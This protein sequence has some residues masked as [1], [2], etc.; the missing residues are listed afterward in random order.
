MNRY[1]KL[2]AEYDEELDIEEHK[3]RCDGLY[4]DNVIW[5]KA[6]L[7]SAEKLSIVAEELGHYK[8]TSGDILDQTITSNIKQELSARKWAYEKVIPLSEL[9]LAFKQNIVEVYD[10]A[11]HFEVTEEFMRECLKHYKLLDIALFKV[12]ENKMGIFGKSKRDLQ[13]END[14]L[15]QELDK[16]KSLMTPELQSLDNVNKELS[17]A[18]ETLSSLEA[19]ISDYDNEL[20]KLEEEISLRKSEIIELDDAISLQDFGIYSPIYNFASS[21]QY[22]DRLA[23]IRQEQKTMIKNK[24]AVIFPDNFT[25]NGSAAKGKSLVNDNIKQ[26]LRSFNNE[27]DVLIN[28]VKFNTIDNT[29]KKIEKSFEQ[30][31]KMNSRMEIG[32]VP[33]YL[34]LKLDELNLAYEYA[35]KKQE[36]KE[37]QKEER[38]RLRE[39]A[40]LQKEIEEARKVAEKEKQHYENALMSV[41]DQLSLS[42]NNDEL[43]AKKKELEEHLGVIK[44]NIEEID[45]REAN[46]RAGYVYV[47]SN[48]GSFGEN[49]Y[50]IGMT[51]RLEPLDRVNELGDAS[52]PFNF[53]VHAMIFSDDAPSLEN[54]L[55]HAFENR[56]VNMVN[57]RREFFNVTLEEIEAVVKANFDKTVEFRSIPE[58]EQFRES[59]MIKKSMNY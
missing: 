23:V 49:I 45:Y 27:C 26:I 40:K 53:D 20:S 33:S 21:E 51:R 7:T 34:A 57:A 47:I 46:K 3:M 55:H 50:K 4:C 36:E 15:A 24:T 17:R 59:L 22:K 37:A 44:H 1:E 19:R 54:A 12:K 18:K 30:L 28:N 6:G 42:P 43:I 41:I 5:V 56:K 2:I 25:L 31:N 29:R 48:I 39:E 35:Q 10:L 52:V 58:A 13:S 16:L 9:M 32:I 14:S 38:A 8:T 11:E